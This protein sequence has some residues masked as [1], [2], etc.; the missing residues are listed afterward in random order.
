MEE[1]LTSAENPDIEEFD[2]MRESVV[3][4]HSEKELLNEQILTVEDNLRCGSPTLTIDPNHVRIRM[5]LKPRQRRLLTSNIPSP[6]LFQFEDHRIS[7]PAFSSHSASSQSPMERTPQRYSSVRDLKMLLGMPSDGG[8]SHSS[9]STPRSHCSSDG[10]GKSPHKRQN[11]LS[12]FIE[13]GEEPYDPIDN[14]LDIRKTPRRMLPDIS[15][16]KSPISKGKSPISEGKSPI[17]KGKSPIS[18]GKSPI[19]KGKSTI[20]KGKSPAKID[21]KLADALKKIDD[22]VDSNLSSPNSNN[23]HL[24]T[25]LHEE[26]EEENSLQKLRRLTHEFNFDKVRSDAAIGGGRNSTESF[27]D[28]LSHEDL[29]NA[30]TRVKTAPDLSGVDFSALKTAVDSIKVG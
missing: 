7:S 1:Y 27:L 24:K 17:S 16:G 2:I 3:R 4:L 6:A 8:G 23:N 15:K 26:E 22:L 20:S 11:K 25:S 10:S 30:L 12:A 21:G 19:F 29:E 9:R 14:D 28:K 5:D 13:K 18:E